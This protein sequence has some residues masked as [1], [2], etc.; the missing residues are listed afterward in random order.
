MQIEVENLKNLALDALKQAKAKGA[1]QAQISLQKSAGFDVKV[2]LGEVDTISF[3]RDQGIDIEVY[4][5]QRKGIAS[6]SDL[7]EKSI[8]AAVNIA[9][10]MAKVTQADSFAGLA[11]AQYMA[12]DYPNLDLYHPWSIEMPE[13]IEW[14]KTCEEAALGFD[15]RINNSEGATLA[16]HS[17]CSVYA[18]SHGFIGSYLGSKHSVSCVVIAT[19]Q[20]MQRDYWYTAARDAKLLQS[21]KTVGEMAAQRT[22][23][24]LN[25]KRIKTGQAQV[26][27]AA[28]VASSLWGHFLAAIAGGNLYRNASFLCDHLKQK[29]FP[30]F[31]HV[32][33][34]PHLL[35]AL[36]SAPFDGEGLATRAQDFI[37]QGILQSYMLDSYA[38]RKLNLIPTGSASGVHN[39]IIDPSDLNLDDLFKQMGTGLYV[40]ELMGQGV[41]ILTGDYSRGVTGFWIENGVIQYPVHEITIAG[42]L[43]DMF[44]N[45]IAV[46]N[47]IDRRGNILTGSVWLDKM[48]IAGE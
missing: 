39:L 15:K 40:T 35:G 1:A 16:T 13:A 24:K 22:L 5:G 2:R 28:E 8:E 25:A 48:M 42:N 21:S 9:C 45:M 29:I 31:I 20:D 26:I 10:E 46:G 3:N 37:H 11:D 27:F 12:Q 33:E 14:A 32:H 38:A 19:Q 34:A 4:D 6:T 43:R 41:N 17:G 44:A 7:T 23:N 47:D 36:G 18:N 30:E